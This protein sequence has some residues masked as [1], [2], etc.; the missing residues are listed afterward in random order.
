MIYYLRNKYVVV[1]DLHNLLNLVKYWIHRIQKSMYL[2]IKI[3]YDPD[4][5]KQ[6]CTLCA[7]EMVIL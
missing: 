5:K 1:N 6:Y 4:T 2:C 7:V 3:I